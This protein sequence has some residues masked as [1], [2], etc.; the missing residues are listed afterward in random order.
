M[1]E[2]NATLIIDTP[3]G[4][5]VEEPEDTVGKLEAGQYKPDGRGGWRLIRRDRQKGEE[6]G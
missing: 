6:Y 3:S 2:S 1:L 4:L 5:T